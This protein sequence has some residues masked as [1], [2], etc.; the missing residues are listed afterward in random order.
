MKISEASPVMHDAEDANGQRLTVRWLDLFF[1]IL[2]FTIVCFSCWKDRSCESCKVANKPPIA[3]AGQDQRITLP[4]DSISLDGSASNDPDGKITDWSWKKIAGPASFNIIS[5]GTAKTL[6]KNMV[7]GVYQFELAVTDDKGLFAKD[8]VMVTVDS[9]AKAN[10]P[11]VANAGTDQTIPINTVNL[12][13][14]GSTDPDNNITSYQWT[15][16][17]GPSSFFITSTNTVKTQVTNLV[18]GVYQFELKV[19]DAGGLFDKDTAQVIVQ[20]T[21]PSS[22]CNNTNRPQINVQLIPIGTLSQSRSEMSVASAGNKILFAGGWRN[23]QFSESTRVDIYDVATN[24]WSTAELSFPRVWIGAIAAGNKIFF[25]G[26]Q[27]D[28]ASYYNVDIYDLATNTWTLSKLSRVADGL[29]AAAVG[30][31]VFFAGGNWGIYATGAVDIY[32]LTTNT[33]STASLSVPRN[34]ITAV[35]SGNKVYFSGGDPWTG[36]KSNVIDI[37]DNTSNTWSTST[38]QVPRVY[39]AATAMNDI[40]YFAGGSTTGNSPTCSVETLNTNTGARS[41]M[42]LFGPA[43]WLIDAGQNAVVKDNKIIFLRQG[44]GVNANKFDIYDVQANTWSIGVLSQPIPTGASVISANNTV[45]VGGGSVNGVLSNQ[46][47]KLEF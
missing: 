22:D 16:I 13:G 45:Y 43:S 14:S 7:V 25:A 5:P 29:A 23:V 42:N 32:D 27:N 24:T 37:Y 11:P 4:T 35:S 3:N 2:M 38:L 33:W 21:L 41:M 1:V 31:K 34:F 26:G 36:Q 28:G 8:T 30:N 19:T 6:V 10:H 40:L 18:E 9:T 46:V 39:H 44:G 47:W 17:S 12:D 20:Q 15:K